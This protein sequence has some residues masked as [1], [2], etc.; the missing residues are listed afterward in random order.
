MRPATSVSRRRIPGTLSPWRIF[1]NAR[2]LR[3]YNMAMAADALNAEQIES[4]LRDGS[5]PGSVDLQ[6]SVIDSVDST[7]SEMMLRLQQVEDRGLHANVL[8]AESQHGGRGR[9]GAQWDMRPGDDLAFSIV[10]SM[11]AGRAIDG[12]SL[13]VGVALAHPLAVEGVRIKWPNDLVLG[14]AKLGGILIETR[15]RGDRGYDVIAGV[16]LNLSPTQKPE[17]AALRDLIGAARTRNELAAELTLALGIALEQFQHY[18]FAHFVNDFDQLDALK[19]QPLDLGDASSLKTP[20][21]G[22]GVSPSG[23][24]RVRT[25]TGELHELNAGVVSLRSTYADLAESA[26]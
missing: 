26:S 19:G 7:N 12:L 20:V 21:V 22:A 2:V 23:A 15:L 24:L 18:G 5:G 14:G 11:P 9:R 25:D 4:L 1:T 8:F 6:V 13:A 3:C 17:R 16:G 10:W